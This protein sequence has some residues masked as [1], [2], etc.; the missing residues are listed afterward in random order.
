MSLTNKFL[1]IFIFPLY[2]YCFLFIIAGWNGLF[3]SLFLPFRILYI[4]SIAS[5]WTTITWTTMCWS[6]K[7]ARKLKT[8][9]KQVNFPQFQTSMKRRNSRQ[10][11]PKK[12]IKT[13]PIALFESSI[14]LIFFIITD[15]NLLNLNLLNTS[16]A[17]QLIFDIL[18]DLIFIHLQSLTIY[19]EWYSSPF[20]LI[21]LPFHFYQ[22]L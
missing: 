18:V 2:P 6:W 17:L 10:L 5:I 1:T 19:M 15:F 21:A 4:K 22:A 9:R 8:R 12:L 7:T 14:I 13:A 16:I 20:H 11:L 3:Q